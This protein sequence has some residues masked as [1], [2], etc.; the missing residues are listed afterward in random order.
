MVGCGFYHSGTSFSSNTSDLQKVS[1]FNQSSISI[2]QC[3]L[4]G[5]LIFEVTF[6]FDSSLH[7]V[8]AKHLCKVIFS[9]IVLK[10]VNDVLNNQKCAVICCQADSTLAFHVAIMLILLL[11]IFLFFIFLWLL[12]G[13]DLVRN[14]V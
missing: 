5:T 1:T 9:R 13:V 7:S 10:S 4:S 3:G 14:S 2:C 8:C 12:E 11:Y 6:L